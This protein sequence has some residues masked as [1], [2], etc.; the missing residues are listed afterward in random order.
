MSR[1]FCAVAFLA[2]IVLLPRAALIGL[3]GCYVDPIGRITAQ[4][5]AL[6]AHTAITMASHGDWATPRFMG[7]FALYKPPLLYWA[8]TF[9]AKL[10]GISRLT[11]RLPVALIAALSAGLVFLWAAEV[12]KWP[13]GAAAALLLLSNRL[14]ITMGAL[15]MTDALLVAFSVAAFYVLFSDPWLES[16]G[17][18]LAFAGAVAAAILTKGIAGILPLG[19]LG[20]YWLAAPRRYRPTFARVCLA[21]LL[22]VLFAAPW[23]VYQALVH[24]RWF[25][26]EHIG[27]E[28]LG[29]GGGAPPQTSREPQALFYLL[30]L[31]AIDPILL[32]LAAGALPVFWSDLRRRSPAA[33]LLACWIAIAAAGVLVWQYRNA[34]YLLP[35]VPALAIL[36]TAHSPFLQRRYAGWTLACLGAVFVAKCALPDMSWGLS[37][38]EATVQPL[39]A[40]LATY[41]D[42]HRGNPLIIVDVAD[43][44]YASAL[45]L[46]RLRYA[47]VAPGLSAGPRY[48]MPFEQMGITVTVPRF[49]DLPAIKPQLRDR[50]RQWGIDSAA[51]IAT[52]ILARDPEELGALTMAHGEADFLVPARY[53]SAV[54]LAPHAVSP[55]GRDYFFLISHRRQ[56]RAAPP[57]WTC[58][59]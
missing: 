46:E 39:A 11:L 2:L 22:A 48:G 9:S 49:N 34:S 47:A 54:A 6:Y 30:R 37:F 36:A 29:Y 13:A 33:T 31:G 17:A 10:L 21:G 44:L 27:I 59:M 57:A 32:A 19:V 51:P 42:Q 28:I 52:L 5:E 8:S 40:P 15:C 18:L 53:R 38:N 23:F 50:L 4:D 7:R 58:H 45:P 41:C 1:A 12:D 20:L 55:A 26:M 56:E 35:L 14:W 3:A 25:W 24:P 16:R 43:D